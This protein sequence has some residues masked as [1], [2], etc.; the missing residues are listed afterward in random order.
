M[1]AVMKQQI[2]RVEPPSPDIPEEWLRE[3]DDGE[4]RD[5]NVVQYKPTLW[6]IHFWALAN[7]R[8]VLLED[9]LRRRIPAALLDVPGVTAVDEHD[10]E[11]YDVSGRTTGR[12]LAEAGAR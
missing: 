11:S 3:T 8:D 7:L 1:L 12:A 5:L 10:W 9:E 4:I 2:R 6:Q